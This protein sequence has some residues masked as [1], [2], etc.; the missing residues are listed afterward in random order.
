MVIVVAPKP[1]N[2]G[3]YFLA[4]PGQSVEL[5]VSISTYM[6]TTTVVVTSNNY[7]SVLLNIR[8]FQE[9]EI[10]AYKQLNITYF[11]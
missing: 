3:N 10:I 7:G 6:P 9:L 2:L 4:S 1:R 8:G 5:L 11:A